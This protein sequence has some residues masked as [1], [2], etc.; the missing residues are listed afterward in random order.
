MHQAGRDGDI[1]CEPSGACEA[2]L[3]VASFTQVGQPHAT[4]AA[5]ATEQEA[6]RYYLVAWRDAAHPL[7]DGDHLTGPFMARNNGITIVAFRPDTTVEFY[8]AAADTD[9]ARAN[10]HIFRAHTELRELVHDGLA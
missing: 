10:H 9:R 1:L 3:F 7:A 2:N 6:L 8:I 4:I 5:D